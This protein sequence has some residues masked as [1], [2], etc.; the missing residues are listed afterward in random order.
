MAS[1]PHSANGGSKDGP[2]LVPVE[3]LHCLAA[4][5][6][7]AAETPRVVEQSP[8]ARDSLVVLAPG[9]KATVREED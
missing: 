3:V 5:G 1:W 4:G 2:A 6:R 8:E 7:P 9:S